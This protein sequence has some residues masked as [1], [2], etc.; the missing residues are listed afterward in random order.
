[1]TVYIVQEVRGRDISSASSYGNLEILLTSDQ[2]MENYPVKEMG[3]FH[4]KLK[5]FN[6]N[7]FLLL[8][9]DPV[10][11]A[12]ASCIAASNNNGRIKFL[13]WD[14][15]METYFKIGARVEEEPQERF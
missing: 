15:K 3:I 9:G 13:R 14:R 10:A 4:N 7:D 5:N 2:V 6:D 1:M 12:L 8:S 11:I